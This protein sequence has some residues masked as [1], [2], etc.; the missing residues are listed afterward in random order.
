MLKAF[1]HNFLYPKGNITYFAIYLTFWREI[2]FEKKWSNIL[3]IKLL[4]SLT[5]YQTIKYLLIELLNPSIITRILLY[6]GISLTLPNQPGMSTMTAILISMIGCF[7]HLCYFKGEK[8]VFLIFEK[9]LFANSA[10]T[11][12]WRRY[13]GQNI[14]IYLIKY[15]NRLLKLGTIISFFVC[16]FLSLQTFNLL[17]LKY[18]FCRC[19]SFLLSHLSLHSNISKCKNFFSLANNQL[20]P[21]SR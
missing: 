10:K 2:V 4:I 14:C 6:D 1:I 8:N 19:F 20:A 17:N 15:S 5:M 11:L 16:M 3:I 18:I 9:I 21:F 7:L 13:K 12:I